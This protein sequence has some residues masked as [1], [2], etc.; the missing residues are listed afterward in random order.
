MA[1][2]FNI[3]DKH[4]H[5]DVVAFGLCL[6]IW[7]NTAAHVVLVYIL[8]VKFGCWA[9]NLKRECQER[10]HAFDCNFEHVIETKAKNITCG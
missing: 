4:E 2:I 1:L 3:V 8:L 6:Y 5:L 9:I 7:Y 10:S